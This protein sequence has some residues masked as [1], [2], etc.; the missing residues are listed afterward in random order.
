MECRWKVCGA[1]WEG[2]LAA[3]EIKKGVLLIRRPSGDK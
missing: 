3:Q 1:A 2:R